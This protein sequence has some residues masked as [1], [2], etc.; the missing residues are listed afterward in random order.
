MKLKHE[1]SSSFIKFHMSRHQCPTTI[2]GLSFS[3]IFSLW[4]LLFFYIKLRLVH[5]TG[6]V[7]EFNESG[8][9]NNISQKLA[10]PLYSLPETTSIEQVFWHVLGN[11]SN[12]VCKLHPPQEE[13]KLL[14][15]PDGKLQPNYDELRNMTEAEEKTKGMNSALVNITH[16]L[17]SDGSV[18][19]YASESKGAKVVA[20]N[21]EAKGATNILGKDHDKYLRNPCSVEG[22][23]VVIE[24]SEETLVDS[25]K[26]AN[27]EHYSSNFKEFDLAGSLSYPTEEWSVLGR[28]I[29]SNVKHAQVFKLSEPKCVRYLKLTLLSH[30]GS[31]FYCTLSVVEVYGIN[32]IER[33]LK[34]LIV[35]SVGYIPDKP[36]EDNIS[37]TPS[38]KSEDGQ[39]DKNG[40][41]VDTK[42]DTVAAQ[43]SSNDTT[44]EYDAEAVKT[45]VTANLIPDSVLELRQQL[46]GRVAGDTV[47]KILM[48]KV[49]SVEVNLSALEEILKEMNRKQGAKIPDLEKE[50]S[51][52]SESLGESKSEI[53]DLWHWNTNLEKGISEVDSWKDAVSSQLNELARENSMLRSDV[54]KIASNQANM[55]TKELA[56]LATSLIFV[57]LALLKIVSVYMLT[58]FASY[59]TNK[60]PQTIRGWVTLFVCC[61][62]TIFI[63][64]FNS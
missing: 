59:N 46:N 48:K 6:A 41:K 61:S 27:F 44:R 26:I 62:V 36:P 17:E 56:V 19:N 39:N 54:Q 21:K 8:S 1:E 7:L 11:G 42:N 43:I 33:M 38:L 24:L 2:F 16:R 5:G 53:K 18:Y 25:V 37:E 51:R 23:F 52:L 22:K 29:A 49:R 20:H 13:N 30:Y 58:F 34:D 45:T 31:E 14:Q 15:I 60:V 40:K 10:K 4:C 55:E 28:F 63:I 35:A 9:T 3:F 12:L 32:A 47:L 64:L 50:L 57:C